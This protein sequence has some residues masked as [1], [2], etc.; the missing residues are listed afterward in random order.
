MI[1]VIIGVSI[2]LLF[3]IG[4]GI[5]LFV[6]WFNGDDD[7]DDDDGNGEDGDSGGSFTPYK[8]DINNLVGS[9]VIIKAGNGFL[10]IPT[11]CEN[12]GDIIIKSNDVFSILPKIKWNVLQGKTIFGEAG[13]IFQ[14]ESNP[15]TSLSYTLYND[16]L[17][18]SS[19][20]T[21]TAIKNNKSNV[22]LIPEVQGS[23]GMYKM[24]LLP[25]TQNFNIPTAAKYLTTSGYEFSSCKL[26]TL[27]YAE[28]YI[29]S[30]NYKYHIFQFMKV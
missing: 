26:Q 29:D 24:V 5:Y 11:L 2:F 3:I 19:N 10:G 8:G 7:D 9:K 14:P 22:F 17:L 28:N 18:L 30:D 1:W 21:S 25:I 27:L 16:N 20:L 6:K 12:N 15:E 13:I 23:P 4:V